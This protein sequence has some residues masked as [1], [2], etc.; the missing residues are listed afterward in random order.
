MAAKL[1]VSSKTVE[2]N[3]ARVYRKLD[4]RSR[5]ELGARPAAESACPYKRRETPDSFSIRRS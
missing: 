1:F 3:L 5:A 2:A 4:I